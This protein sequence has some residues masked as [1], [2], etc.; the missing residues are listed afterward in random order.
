MPHADP[1]GG[2]RNGSAFLGVALRDSNYSPGVNFVYGW[3]GAGVTSPTCKDLKEVGKV[4]ADERG[5]LGQGLNF[6]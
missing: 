2:D 5:V 3:G 6:A 1:H 4:V